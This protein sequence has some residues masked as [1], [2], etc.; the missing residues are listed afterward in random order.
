MQLVIV[1]RGG[2]QGLRLGKVAR[3][4]HIHCQRRRS[5]SLASDGQQ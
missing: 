1:V 2:G 4:H 3:T 5:G